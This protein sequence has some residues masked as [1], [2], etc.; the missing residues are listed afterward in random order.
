MF[1][2]SRLPFHLM[3]GFKLCSKSKGHS[4]AEIFSCKASPDIDFGIM[5]APR[6][7]LASADASVGVP[8]FCDH[9]VLHAEHIKPQ[10][11][12]V[13]PVRTRPCLAHVN[14]DHVLVPDH[15]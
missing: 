11:L 12:M 14:D 7:G 6:H 4:V 13:L 15:I 8:V 1:S 5:V 10:R 9:A 3:F 2:R